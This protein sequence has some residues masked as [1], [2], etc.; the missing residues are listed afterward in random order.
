MIG[1]R[2]V[3]EA[4]YRPNPQTPVGGVDV[5]IVRE[6]GEPGGCA[7]P[8][9]VPVRAFV[10]DQHLI[11]GQTEGEVRGSAVVAGERGE[12]GEVKVAAGG[13]IRKRGGGQRISI[14]VAGEA[15]REQEF[16]GEALAGVS[17]AQTEV[18]REQG[19]AGIERG[20]GAGVG[21]N[22]YDRDDVQIT[23]DGHADLCAAA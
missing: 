16:G 4:Y 20:Q 2:S 7:D 22:P 12:S 5:V 11:G 10:A 18:G 17:G 3:L 15:G 14:G 6:E 23:A 21:L 13:R 19:A 9:R 8:G 1:M